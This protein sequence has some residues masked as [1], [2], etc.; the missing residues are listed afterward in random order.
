MPEEEE[1]EEEEEAEILPICPALKSIPVA[2][3]N[4]KNANACRTN[5]SEHSPRSREL[6]R[7]RILPDYSS[8]QM[9]SDDEIGVKFQ[10]WHYLKIL[11]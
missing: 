4:A 5:A 8:S 6:K 7:K 9:S 2:N 3:A 1:D 11:I 10:Y